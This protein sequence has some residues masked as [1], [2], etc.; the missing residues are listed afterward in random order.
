MKRAFVNGKIFTSD[1]SEPGALYAEALLCDGGRILFAG[2]E[3]DLPAGEYPRIDLGGRTVIPGFVDAHMHPVMLADFSRQ[4]AC[5]PPKVNSIQE[6]IQE[7]ARV[8]SE[9]PEGGWIKGWGYDEGKFAEH[10][11]PN[12]YDLDKGS[13][14]FPVFLTR[15]AERSN[16]T[17]TVNLP[18]C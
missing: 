11:S 1:T 13:S 4:I 2:A 7:I 16:V 8:R 12:R 18:E 5:L 6:L 10:R 15:R 3:K 9:K 17:S 14:D